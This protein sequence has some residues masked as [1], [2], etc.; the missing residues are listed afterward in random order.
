[1]K[2]LFLFCRQIT[3][4]CEAVSLIRVG[5]FEEPAYKGFFECFDQAFHGRRSRWS[6]RRV[7]VELRKARLRIEKQVVWIR[8]WQA[9]V[10][11]SQEFG[12]FRDAYWMLVLV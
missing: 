12:F 4:V 1:M 10:V 8:N 7:F 3:P 6:V 11:L 5:I 9:D 2:S